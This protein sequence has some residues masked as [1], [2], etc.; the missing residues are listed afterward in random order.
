LFAGLAGR[1]KEWMELTV[2]FVGARAG[3]RRK[4]K[5]VSLELTCVA[6][7]GFGAAREHHP[8]F[9]W[10]STSGISSLIWLPLQVQPSV[11]LWTVFASGRRSD[12]QGG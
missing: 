8:L 7:R 10:A 11:P 5:Y 1:D 2:L 3:K 6:G 12:V 9:S 4:I